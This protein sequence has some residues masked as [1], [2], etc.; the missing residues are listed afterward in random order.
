MQL[1]KACALLP[2]LAWAASRSHSDKSRLVV[3]FPASILDGAV[4]AQLAKSTAAANKAI[5]MDHSLL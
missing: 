3:L 4:L 2:A 5:F 1:S